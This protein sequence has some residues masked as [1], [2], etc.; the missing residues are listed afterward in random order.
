MIRKDDRLIVAAKY[1]IDSHVEQ[2]LP[3]V[4]VVVPAYNSAAYIGATLHS[5]TVQTYPYIEIIVVDDGSVDHT[6]Q[7]VESFMRT[8]DRI[9]L[10]QQPNSGVAVARNQGIQAASGQFVAPVDSDDI[11]YPKKIEKLLA[12]MLSSSN[13]VGLVYGWSATIDHRGLL[14]GG[15]M[16][17]QVEDDVFG[18][19]VYTN[20]IGNASACLIRKDCLNL[21]GFYNPAYLEQ[22]AQGCEDYDLYLRI[23]EHFKFRVVKDFLT[24]YR[25]TG[26][27][28]SFDY[29]A[30]EKS[31]RLVVQDL[32]LRNPWIPNIAFHWAHSSYCLWIAARANYVGCFKDSIRYLLKAAQYDAA[33]L[34]NSCYVYKQLSYAMWKTY[35]TPFR[36]FLSNCKARL[37]VPRSPDDGHAKDITLEKLI[38]QAYRLDP[39]SSLM[40]FRERRRK[41]VRRII[42]KARNAIVIRQAFET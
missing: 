33:L 19:L 1:N 21:V 34:T 9:K 26:K 7:I 25:S 29:R 40:L 13:D 27:G 5:L 2:P 14:T 31:R 4:S 8:D 16:A 22:K 38:E 17:K 39:P 37:S 24:G 42:T 36:P 32:K 20:F 10:I 18:D 3:L 30:M 35:G 15:Y 28:M 6:A 12:C 11:C 23:A 41:A